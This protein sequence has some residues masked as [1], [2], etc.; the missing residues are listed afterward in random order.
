MEFFISFG[1]ATLQLEVQPS[2]S[3]LS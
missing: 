1:E 3:Q 2:I